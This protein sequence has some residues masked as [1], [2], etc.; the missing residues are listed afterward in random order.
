[1][2]LMN[3]IRY[4]LA[5]RL[6]KPLLPVYYHYTDDNPF[7]T[8]IMLACCELHAHKGSKKIREELTGIVIDNVVINLNRVH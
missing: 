4:N 8:C 5:M 1:M 7:G 2:K 6:L 3:R